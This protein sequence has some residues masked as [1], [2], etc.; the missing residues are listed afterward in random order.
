MRERERERERERN[1]GIVLVLPYFITKKIQTK[2]NERLNY[3]PKFLKV[4]K[5][6]SEA[7][8]HRREAWAGVHSIM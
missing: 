3:D 2:A 8:A 6:T 5:L 7:E 4:A 1:V